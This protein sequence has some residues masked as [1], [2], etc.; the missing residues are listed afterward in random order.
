MT[1]ISIRWD[2]TGGNKDF[3]IIYATDVTTSDRVRKGRVNGNEIE[4]E[5]T[6]L[7]PG[8]TYRIEVEAVSG[9]EDNNKPS[10]P[11]EVI[12]ETSKSVSN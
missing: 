4:F 9:T 7:I 3:Y 2:D 6:D 10:T 11:S 12:E 1:S 8:T 5:V